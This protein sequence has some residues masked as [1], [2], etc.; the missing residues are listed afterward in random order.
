MKLAV[1]KLASAFTVYTYRHIA[2][3]TDEQMDQL[4]AGLGAVGLTP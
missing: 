4:V 1:G 2:A 3:H